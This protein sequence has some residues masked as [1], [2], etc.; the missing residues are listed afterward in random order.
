[1]RRIKFKVLQIKK[2]ER[3]SSKRRKKERKRFVK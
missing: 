2:D 1:M 3:I